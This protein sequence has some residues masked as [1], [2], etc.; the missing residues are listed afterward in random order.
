MHIE[1]LTVRFVKVQLRTKLII[2]I[3][4]IAAVNAASLGG[5]VFL[6]QA[7]FLKDNNCV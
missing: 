5:L 1:G 4:V 6:R 7:E 2:S 3:V